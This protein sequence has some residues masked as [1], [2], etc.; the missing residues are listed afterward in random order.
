MLG[1]RNDGHVHAAP[2][3]PP[4][5]VAF[6]D[7]DPLAGSVS[8]VLTFSKAA[9][10]SDIDSYEIYLWDSV[11][12]SSVETFA[13]VPSDPSAPS[14]PQY[15]VT[16]DRVDTAS[17]NGDQFRVYSSNINGDGA[18]A[19]VAIYNRAGKSQSNNKPTKPH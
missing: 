7:A 19:A 8:G 6:V 9:S 18:H 14:Y 11:R 13:S 15:T 4:E 3:H 17:V 1:G 12:N 10:D 2:L 16:V 5:N